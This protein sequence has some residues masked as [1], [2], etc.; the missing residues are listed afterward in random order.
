MVTRVTRKDYIAL[1]DV[2]ER[3]T[4]LV[5]RNRGYAVG[6]HDALSDV[7]YALC[8]VLRADNPR[9]DADRFLDACNVVR[10]EKPTT[11]EPA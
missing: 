4:H 7:A 9:F 8:V 11:P 1:A 5:S 10:R 2:I 6:W 3:R